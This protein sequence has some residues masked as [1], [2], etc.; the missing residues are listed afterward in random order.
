[1]R[2]EQWRDQ[3]HTLEQGLLGVF[4]KQGD[5]RLGQAL[6]GFLQ[7]VADALV[8]S[9]QR[10]RLGEEQEL[11]HRRQLGGHQINARRSLRQHRFDDVGRMPGVLEHAAQTV[12][13]EGEQRFIDG[14]ER[15]SLFDQLRL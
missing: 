2:P 8:G 12:M 14:G 5:V 3:Q 1:M 10:Q 4:L 11:A 15:D 6:L 7:D 9:R 13:E